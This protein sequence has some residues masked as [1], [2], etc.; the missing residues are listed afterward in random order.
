[1]SED[2]TIGRSLGRI[3]LELGAH[4]TVEDARDLLDG[5]KRRQQSAQAVFRTSRA[6]GDLHGRRGISRAR[7]R[8]KERGCLVLDVFEVEGVGL[9]AWKC[10]YRLS[11]KD[12]V[13]RC[14]E[15]FRVKHPDQR[16][17][18]LTDV[19]LP[20]DLEY[21]LNCDCGHVRDFVVSGAEAREAGTR[22]AGD[23]II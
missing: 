16:V 2:N 3:E 5:S 23:I 1:M 14:S 15:S 19:L 11:E 9:C 13:E 10:S 7:W 18:E 20:D 6:A 17:P 22:R 4:F 21:W 8:C 12:W